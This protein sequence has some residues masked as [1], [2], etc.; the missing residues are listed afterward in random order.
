MENIIDDACGPQHSPNAVSSIEPQNK[1]RKNSRFTGN[2]PPRTDAK[3]G[4]ALNTAHNTSVDFALDLIRVNQQL[5][6]QLTLY[7]R[8]KKHMHK[9]VKIARAE[10]A[11]NTLFLR[12][13]SHELHTQ[14]NAIIGFSDIIQS[15]LSGKPDNLKY[16]EYARH[17]NQSGMQLMRLMSDMLDIARMEA[18]I[19]DIA[20]EEFD[21]AGC[22]AS[23]MH[24]V[25]QQAQMRRVHLLRDI[26][27]DLPQM[28]GDRT[29]I[30]QI[31]TC[32]MRDAIKF[33]SAEG[34]VRVSAGKFSDGG[35]EVDISSGT[36]GLESGNPQKMLGPLVPAA[37]TL[38][39]PYERVGL[40]LLM[41]RLLIKSHDGVLTIDSK[42]EGDARI[43]VRFPASRIVDEEAASG[44]TSV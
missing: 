41:A 5:K 42:P 43:T 35:I 4:T 6:N 27:G 44:R 38:T 31:F 40:E 11:S 26:A 15:E 37:N 7:K 34:H 32:L 30:R 1:N 22:L 2:E 39:P 8:T 10:S 9:A 21:F 24:M 28:R 20:E 18:G 36:I 12:D 16:A 13:I 29:R 25:E 33:T 14:L 19:F 3:V 17:I 23:S